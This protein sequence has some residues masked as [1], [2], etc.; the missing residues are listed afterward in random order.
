M[1]LSY[2]FI[3][4][5]L[6]APSIK[7]SPFVHLEHAQAFEPST[8]SPSKQQQQRSDNWLAAAIPATYD[9]IVNWESHGNWMNNRVLTARQ[10]KQPRESASDVQGI[11][12]IWGPRMAEPVSL[13]AYQEDFMPLLDHERMQSKV[14][15]AVSLCS[16]CIINLHLTIVI[17]F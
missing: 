8:V 11:R 15:H 14:L 13:E 7:T 2:N 9:V 1:K 3:S 17:I 4:D 16:Q 6:K 12:V 5:E 10:A